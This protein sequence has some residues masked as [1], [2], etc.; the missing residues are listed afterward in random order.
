MTNQW[1]VSDR[2]GREIYITEERWL[3]I[4]SK[5]YE[6]I[7]HLDDVLDTLRRGRRRQ[8]RR[9]PQ[10]YRY[11]RECLTLRDGNNYIT[12]VVVFSF[13]EQPDGELAANNFVTTAWGERIPPF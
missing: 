3:H 7:G 6:L 10:R 5:H 1:T 8:E 4:L 11:Q 12:V 13:Q 9:D 2:N